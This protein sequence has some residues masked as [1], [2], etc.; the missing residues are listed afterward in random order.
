MSAIELQAAHIIAPHISRTSVV[1]STTSSAR[2]NLAAAAELGPD[3]ES[4]KFVTMCADG[5]DVYFFFN[6]ND[7]GTADGAQ[8]SGTNRCFVLKDGLP[9]MFVL[10]SGYTWLV[11][12]ASGAC[13]IRSY[14]SSKPPSELLG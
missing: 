6:N 10:R 3:C 5:A 13:V 14:I 8:T 9:Q 2:V 7:A 1:A 12:I 11:H 4:G